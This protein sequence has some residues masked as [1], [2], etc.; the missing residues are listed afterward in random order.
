MEALKPREFIISCLGETRSLLKAL[1]PEIY[2][3]QVPSLDGSIGGHL[4]HSL[5][6][7]QIFLNGMEGEEVYF[8]KRE[9]R[10]GV[11][12]DMETALLEIAR[13]EEALQ[14]APLEGAYE[15]PMTSRSSLSGDLRESVEYPSVW[16]RELVYVGL[17]FVHHMALMAVA[18]R[19]QGLEVD[20][21]FG[22]APATLHFE[23]ATSR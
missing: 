22:K 14:S 8:E 9:R 21:R 13:L 3:K 2:R 5:E 20:S 11:E 17:H 6:H 23:R 18:A 16:G 7:L 19:L 15:T 12:E 10:K 4:R 1:S